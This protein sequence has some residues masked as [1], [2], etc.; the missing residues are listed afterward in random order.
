MCRKNISLSSIQYKESLRCCKY[1]NE[2]EKYSDIS[3]KILASQQLLWYYI[4][5][6][7]IAAD[8]PVCAQTGLAGGDEPARGRN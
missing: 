7:R 2:K 3:E 6:F 8:L 1:E 5:A 4:S